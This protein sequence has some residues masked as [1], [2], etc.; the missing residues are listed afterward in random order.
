MCAVGEMEREKYRLPPKDTEVVVGFDAGRDKGKSSASNPQKNDEGDEDCQIIEVFDILPISY[1]YPTSST[2]ADAGGQALV[3]GTT[4]IHLRLRVFLVISNRT[5]YL[6]YL[7]CAAVCKPPTIRY[8][9]RRGGRRR[10]ANRR[11]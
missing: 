11:G 7:S 1:A 5:L 3:E 2:S 10:F 8:Y 6:C 4:G 9:H